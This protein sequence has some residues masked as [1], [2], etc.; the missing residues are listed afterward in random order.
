MVVTWWAFAIL[1]VLV[2]LLPL[3]L[4]EGWSVRRGLRAWSTLA[5]GEGDLASTPWR[6]SWWW[7]LLSFIAL[8]CGLAFFVITQLV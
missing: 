4:F 7:I 1:G 5:L 2:A 8:F 6:K 3:L